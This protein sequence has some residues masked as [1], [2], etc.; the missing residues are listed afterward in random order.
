M[1][2]GICSLSIV[3]V[4]ESPDEASGMVSQLLYGEVF[5]VPES[6][7]HW[8]RVRA[9]L[10]QSE[11]WISN[12][13]L[14]IIEETVYNKLGE[15]IALGCAS[16]LISHIEA[17]EGLLLPVP[18]GASVG[19][20]TALNHQHEGDVFPSQQKKQNLVNTAL[21]FLNSPELKGGRSPFGIDAPG[22]SQL[23]YKTQGVLLKRQPDQQA[24]QGTPLSFIEESEPG[25]LAFFDGPDGV[26][27]H[28]GIIMGDN[29]LVHCH[30]KVRIDRLDHTGIFN[31]ELR[32]YT[33]SLRVI[34]RVLE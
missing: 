30:G 34:V 31:T 19:G 16:D 14:Q 15:S 7:K 4:Y 17:E 8:S 24:L 26:I 32:N 12:T 11:G 21:M 3:P 28:V 33:H 6:R 2:Y 9:F 18:L 27:N 20:A 1:Q 23:V 13:Q 29:Y 25:D 5:K 22:L 10:D